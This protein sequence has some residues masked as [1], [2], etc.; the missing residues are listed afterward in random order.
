MTDMQTPHDDRGA[1][2]STSQESATSSKRLAKEEHLDVCIATN[3]Q[4][5]SDGMG[6]THHCQF[7]CHE[8]AFA[9]VVD[10]LVGSNSSGTDPSKLD[11]VKA[12][13]YT[14][15]NG[16]PLLLLLPPA[17]PESICPT[18]SEPFVFEGEHFWDTAA[19]DDYV[20]DEATASEIEY[21]GLAYEGNAVYYFEFSTGRAEWLPPPSIGT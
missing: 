20:H 5:C 17:T 12:C 21:W 14:Y 7:H 10:M 13:E 16:K 1:T 19:V 3:V 18:Q 2:R 15:S 6:T 8:T 11:E 9:G 4:A